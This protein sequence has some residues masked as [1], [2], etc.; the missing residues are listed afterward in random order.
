LFGR[1][2]YSL[3]EAG[4]VKCVFKARR[5]VGP[6]MNIPRKMSVDLSHVDWR[7]HEPTGDRGVVGDANEVFDVSLRSPAWK[8]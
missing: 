3:D 5:A 1:A 2:P 6:R 7:A 8:P 4:V